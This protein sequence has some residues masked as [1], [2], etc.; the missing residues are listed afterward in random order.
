MKS[1]GF[2][3]GSNKFRML[4]IV[5]I[6]AALWVLFLDYTDR[7]AVETEKASIQQT[8]NI[9]NSSLAVVFA[10]YA[11]KGELDRIDEL[12]N[13]NPFVHMAEYNLLPNSFRGVV[14]LTDI[15][16]L[17]PGWYFD[18][19]SRKVFYKAFYSNRVYYFAQVL[20]FRDVNGSGHFEAAIDEYQRLYFK[21]L[22]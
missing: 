10:S 21:Q 15:D 16:N 5:V 2:P 22:P 8:K 17:E 6:V 13:G 9:I 1:I 19:V 12:N 14:E 20:K 7:I 11:V 3:P 4:M 18:I